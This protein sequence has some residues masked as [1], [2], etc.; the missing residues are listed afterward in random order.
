MCSAKGSRTL[1]AGLLYPEAGAVT[2]TITVTG[3]SSGQ[4]P[5]GGTLRCGD[6]SLAYVESVQKEK[7]KTLSDLV[8]ELIL[9]NLE[10]SKR[11]TGII[12]KTVR[13]R[14]AAG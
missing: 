7:N 6:D 11:E 3:S 13:K 5:I 12:K 10:N 4:L 8:N 1:L 14:Q 9:T 2:V